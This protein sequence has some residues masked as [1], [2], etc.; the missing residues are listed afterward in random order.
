MCVS[1]SMCVSVCCFCCSRIIIVEDIF[2]LHLTLD[3]SPWCDYRQH[4]QYPLPLPSLVSPP[5]CR[6][7]TYVSDKV[8]EKVLFVIDISQR[9]K[10]RRGISSLCRVEYSVG[11]LCENCGGGSDWKTRPTWPPLCRQRWPSYFCWSF[12]IPILDYVAATLPSKWRKYFSP[13]LLLLFLL[14][15]LLLHA[16]LPLL[17]LYFSPVFLFSLLFILKL[18]M[19]LF[20]WYGQPARQT[21]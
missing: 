1:V 12:S 17:L 14:F 15:F 10:R 13:L 18:K 6:S 21:C 8:S 9:R 7:F 3:G 20:S 19:I 4:F 5:N 2:I 11:N 16:L